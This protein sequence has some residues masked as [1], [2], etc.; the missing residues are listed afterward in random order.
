M[1]KTGLQLRN[2]YKDFLGSTCNPRSL[3]VRSSGADRGIKSASALLAGL[4]PPSDRWIWYDE[5]DSCKNLARMWQP[6]TIQ[7]VDKSLDSILYGASY[8][9]AVDEEIKSIQIKRGTRKT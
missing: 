8:C 6:I 3:Y 4:C 2:H 5:L 9:P 7:T 1:Y